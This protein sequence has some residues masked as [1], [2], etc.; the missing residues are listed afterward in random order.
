MN[1]RLILLALA[2]FVLLA[3]GYLLPVRSW[4]GMLLEW[5][6]THREISWLVFIVAYV[7]ATV[8]FAPGFILTVSAGA[9][10][11]IAQ[12]FLIVSL[13]STLGATCA[14]FIGRT[15][16][17][18]L[19]AQ[20]IQHFRLLR[21][22]DRALGKKGFWVVLLTRLSPIFPYNLLNYAYGLTGVK[23]R[24]YIFGSW[25]GMAAPTLLYVYIGSLVRNFTAISRGEIQMGN[26]KLWLIGVG[27]AATAGVVI[28]VTRLAQ[29]A[30][31][32]EL[33]EPTATP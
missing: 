3:A 18:D 30:L 9:L 8:L 27:L 10:F 24:D 11:G 22:L 32:E 1:R 17:R 16:A 7:L 6:D 33:V 28:L 21:A 26:G 4:L 20:R 5:I 15:V 12:G 23:V 25:I 31:A 2:A 13:A 19:I 14:F 29:R